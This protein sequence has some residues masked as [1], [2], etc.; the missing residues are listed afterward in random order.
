MIDATSPAITTIIP[1]YRRPELLRRAILS[2]L[3]QTGPA[4]QVCV[5]DN[6]SG[7]STEAV[8]TEL[9]KSDSRVKYFCHPENIG[10]IANFQYGLSHVQTP[11]FSFLSDDDVLLPGFYEAAIR[12][13]ENCPEAA[14]WCG[15]TLLM[16]AS[17]VLYGARAEDW[18]REGMLEAPDG[19]LQM[20]RSMPCWTGALFRRAATDRVGPLNEALAGPSDIEFMLRLAVDHPIV[21]SKHVSAVFLLSPQSFSELQPFESFWP[22]W[23][24]MIKGISQANGLADRDRV[25]VTEGLNSNAQRMLFR[26]GAAAIA[27][28]DYQFSREAATALTRTFDKGGKATLLK[29]LSDTCSRTSLAQWLYT[30]AYRTAEQVVVHKRVHLQKKYAGYAR[31]L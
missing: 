18:L 12:G 1:T 14:F 19:L 11:F 29:V 30:C 16:T 2:A 23:Q 8:V 15:V 5:Y 20:I 17:G 25:A 10:G 21:A 9:A 3:A 13:L 26:R 28:G 6:A 27:K 7:D 24:E 4:L 31:Y 22:G